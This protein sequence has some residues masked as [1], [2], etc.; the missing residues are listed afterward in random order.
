[1]WFYYQSK[2]RI[3]EQPCFNGD[4]IRHTMLWEGIR[5]TH[6]LPESPMGHVPMGS[7]LFLVGV[8]IPGRYYQG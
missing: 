2:K 7:V 5:T 3:S 8:I 1:M 6:K 4:P